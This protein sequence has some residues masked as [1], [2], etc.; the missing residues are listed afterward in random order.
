MR[1]NV[2]KID[3]G[4]SAYELSFSNR[5]FALLSGPQIYMPQG[6]RFMSELGVFENT[7]VAQDMK[8][9]AGSHV[10]RRRGLL[11]NRS[12]STLN[13]LDRDA[14][15][16]RFDYSF[17][18]TQ[19]D[20]RHKP[21]GHLSGFKIRGLFGHVDGQPR[22]FCTLTLSEVSPTGLGRTV[23]II[24]LHG[25]EGI[26]ADD[27]GT[28]KVYRTEADFGWLSALRG[29]IEFL[30]ASIPLHLRGNVAGAVAPALA[31]NTE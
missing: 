30:E 26:E 18:L 31:S 7:S 11:L 22:G 29:M 21:K 16:L 23:E 28:L 13:Y 25:R 20:D 4:D 15:L 6:A 8:I 12:R 10:R 2:L 17:R 3:D 9:P 27:S 14:D 1:M 5:D 24:D 19:G